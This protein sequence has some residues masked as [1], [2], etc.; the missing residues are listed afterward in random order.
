MELKEK[1]ELSKKDLEILEPVIDQVYKELN[2]QS[3]NIISREFV[4]G[5]FI[6]LVKSV[7][8]K[9]FVSFC[10]LHDEYDNSEW[11]EDLYTRYTRIEKA[12]WN[13]KD[14]K[15]RVKGK[16]NY[17]KKAF[18]LRAQIHNVEW[19]YRGLDKGLRN[20]IEGKEII[21]ISY[22]K[23][24]T[25][26]GKDYISCYNCKTKWLLNDQDK[27]PRC[28]KMNDIG[29]FIKLTNQFC[30]L[31]DMRKFYDNLDPKTS[32]TLYDNWDYILKF[33]EKKRRQYYHKIW[34]QKRVEYGVEQYKKIIK[35]DGDDWG[36]GKELKEFNKKYNLA[37]VSGSFEIDFNNAT[38][39]RTEDFLSDV[40]KLRFPLCSTLTLPE[41]KFKAN[42][43][44][45]E[46]QMPKL[47]KLVAKGCFLK[48]VDL[49]PDAF[50][51][52]KE[53]NLDNNLIEKYEN[54]K[55]LI[56]IPS[57]RIVSVFSN[58]IETTNE[59]YLTEEKFGNNLELRYDIRKKYNNP[60]YFIY[61][62]D[63]EIRELKK[64]HIDFI[65]SECSESSDKK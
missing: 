63:E 43:N 19:E 64:K 8:I 44:A 38:N 34:N 60:K 51:S 25:M 59:V 11:L 15:K 4:A 13:S 27:C 32:T 41:V 45:F 36:I 12:D 10:I 3:P 53:I 23:I 17:Y 30:V 20:F 55:N 47:V 18:K 33:F 54:I 1:V 35:Y 49:K 65:D 37:L 56:N 61:E 50:P 22:D 6:A 31:G 57:L 48:E 16:Y 42:L 2:P 21:Y 9:N 24:Q 62:S 52:L 7:P 40:A 39:M 28:D 5:I 14:F 46:P 26:K 58:P 29:M